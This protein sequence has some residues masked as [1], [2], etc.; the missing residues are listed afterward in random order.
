MLH[1]SFYAIDY[2]YC[3]HACLDVNMIF[4]LTATRIGDCRSG[5]Y[6]EAQRNFVNG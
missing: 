6:A 1:T 5:P 4:A 2:L 3:L